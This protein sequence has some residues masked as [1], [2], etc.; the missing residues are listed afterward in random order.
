MMFLFL[1][2]SVYGQCHKTVQKTIT[3][4]VLEHVGY[5]YTNEWDESCKCFKSVAHPQY[6]MVPRTRTVSKIVEVPCGITI[7]IGKRKRKN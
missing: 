4:N 2:V 3:E 5:T 7:P 1:T 6:R